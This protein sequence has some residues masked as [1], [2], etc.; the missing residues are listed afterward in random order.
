MD[1]SSHIGS[2]AAL[3]SA[4]ANSVLQGIGDFDGDSKS[5][6]L[7]RDTVN[8]H[9]TITT[10]AGASNTFDVAAQW[11]VVGVG[12][13]NGNGVDDVLFR[14]TSDGATAY[15]EFTGQ[16]SVSTTFLNGTPPDWHLAALGD[17]DGNGTTDIFWQNDSGANAVWLMDS[18][19]ALST[20]AFFN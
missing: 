14:R 13:L 19:G 15:W 3:G 1:S 11:D 4:P 6:L 5:D 2:T 7:W 16:G 18:S 9:L 17:F 8:D 12:D 10:M 20:A